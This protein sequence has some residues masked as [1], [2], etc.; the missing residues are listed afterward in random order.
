M[1]GNVTVM[2]VAKR[3]HLTKVTFNGIALK[4]RH[5][6]YDASRRLLKVTGLDASTAAGAWRT[7]WFLSWS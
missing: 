2:G 4:P 1:L 6:T 7:E 5:W 3:S